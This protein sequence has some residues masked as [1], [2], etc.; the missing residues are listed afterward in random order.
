M[1][2][3]KSDAP[4]EDEPLHALSVILRR[5]IDDPDPFL[6]LDAIVA[7]FGRRAFG[8]LLFVFSAPNLLPLPPGSSTVLGVPLLLIAPQVALGV[9]RLWL[10]RGLA[11]RRFDTRGVAKAFGKLIPLLERIERI[12]RPRLTFLFG[13]LG[14]RFLGLT[15]TLLGVVLI[16]PIPFGNMLPAAAIGVLALSLVMRD[17][18]L[19]LLGYGLATASWGVLALAAGVILRFFD[20]ALMIAGVA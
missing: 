19:A 12:S 15:C 7:A 11:S 16:F 13:P 8:A 1:S 14:D 6:T 18:L 10:P 4:G 2:E 3:L 20:H 5:L 9:E 17:G